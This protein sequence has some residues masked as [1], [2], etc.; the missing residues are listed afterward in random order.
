M[1]QLVV[2]IQDDKNRKCIKKLHIR[3]RK[4]K[5]LDGIHLNVKD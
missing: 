3:K 4:I 5:T 1:I 2:E